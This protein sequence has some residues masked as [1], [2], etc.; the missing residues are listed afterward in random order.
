MGMRRQT[1][2]GKRQKRGSLSNQGEGFD[3]VD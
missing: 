1:V 2:R 3:E